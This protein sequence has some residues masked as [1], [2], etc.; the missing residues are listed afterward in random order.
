MTPAVLDL[1]LPLRLQLHT[2]PL[3]TFHV[4]SLSC[5]RWPLPA[6]ETSITWQTLYTTIHCPS[7]QRFYLSGSG[8]L[9]ITVDSPKSKVNWERK[10]SF[11]SILVHHNSSSR[12]V[13]AGIQTELATGDRSW[14][15]SYGGVLLIGL[16]PLACST[17]FFIE[18]MDP[19]TM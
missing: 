12:E 5:C 19:P 10:D 18:P 15:R 2:W 14:Y 3:L 13:R 1:N 6:F 8:L 9:L 16:L 17:C 4:S 11:D 7:K